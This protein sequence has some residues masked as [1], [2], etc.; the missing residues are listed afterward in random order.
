MWSRLPSFALVLS[1]AV[2]PVVASAAETEEWGMSG[3]W[4]ILVD[5]TLNNSCFTYIEYEGGTILRMGIDKTED[6]YYLMMFNPD[7]TD[8]EK[9]EKIKSTLYLDNEPWQAEWIGIWWDDLP[10]VEV[11]SDS[12]GF[13]E[14]FVKRQSLRIVHQGEEIDHLSL[15]G[16]AAALLNVLQCQDEMD[17]R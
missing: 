11:S 8:I 4:E 16:S 17:K 12:V 15:E 9:G 3:D 7:W 10:G 1:L 14:D 6:N 13:I 5:R 2:A